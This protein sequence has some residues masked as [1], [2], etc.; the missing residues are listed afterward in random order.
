MNRLFCDFCSKEIKME[1]ETYYVVNFSMIKGEEIDNE[2]I[3][4]ICGNCGEEAKT[5]FD[6]LAEI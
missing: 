5:Q 6:A 1:N 2:T 4:E 3:F